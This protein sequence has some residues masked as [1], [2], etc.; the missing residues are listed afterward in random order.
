MATALGGALSTALSARIN[1]AAPVFVL[2]EPHS[3][4][5]GD[6]FSNDY[7]SLTSNPELRSRFLKTLSQQANRLAR[8]FSA[9]AALLF[10][11]GFTTNLGVLG[12]LPQAGDVIVFDESIHSS[13]R[14]GMSHSRTHPSARVSFAHNSVQSLRECLASVLENNSQIRAGH[15]TLFVVVESLYSMD[16]DT[17]PL[18]DIV[19]TVKELVPAQSAHIV[20]DESHGTGVYG[21]AERGLV[22]LLGLEREVHTRMHTF[23]KAVGSSGAVVL[24][25]PLIRTYLINHARSFIFTTSLPISSLIATSC[26]FDIVEW[27][28]DQLIARLTHRCHFFAAALATHLKAIPPEVLSLQEPAVATTHISPIFP[29]RV[30]ASVELADYL[31][32]A[33]YAATPLTHPLV[34]RG[35][36]RI[37]VCVHAGNTEEELMQFVRV[38][39]A[40]GEKYVRSHGVGLVGKGR[41]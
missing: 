19:R 41:L 30:C 21:A 4:P 1:S 40:W 18:A 15:A 12:T 39:V 24:T 7:L 22:S 9:P 6:L 5:S 36:E 25:S 17:A 2:D 38:L 3:A 10:S 26:S 8:F 28:G 20:V 13:C 14:E 33:G 32:R 27:H 29:I 11:S 16:G 23:G 34:P 35:K 37:R 31:R